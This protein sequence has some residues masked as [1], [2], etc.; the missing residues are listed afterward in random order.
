ML[1]MLEIMSLEDNYNY[2]EKKK[3]MEL[4]NSFEIM[5]MNV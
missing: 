3:E 2:D 5:D 4:M 1:R